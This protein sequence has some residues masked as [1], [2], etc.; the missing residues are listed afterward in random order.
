MPWRQSTCSSSPLRALLVQV[1]A[2]LPR[3]RSRWS[4]LLAGWLLAKLV[5]FAGR[6]RLRA[7]NFNVLTERAGLDGF[8]R[9]GGIESDTTD[10]FGALVYW[11]VI[12]ATLRHRLQR[13]R[14]SPT[15]PTC[16][17]AWCCSCPR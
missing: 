2:F 15:S 13:P 6:A 4:V 17:G 3:L 5:R 16:S 7:I 8:L 1:G 9:Q 10:I 12:F 11:L 14:A